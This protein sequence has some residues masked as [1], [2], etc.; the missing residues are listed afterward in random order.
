MCLIPEGM[1]AILEGMDLTIISFNKTEQN[2][3]DTLPITTKT[4][5]TVRLFLHL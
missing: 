3:K 2:S 4:D 1:E 5:I